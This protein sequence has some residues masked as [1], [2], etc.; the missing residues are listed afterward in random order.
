M[1]DVGIKFDQDKVPAI[2]SYIIG[3]GIGLT[4]HL[5]IEASHM[6]K[7]I[8]V[9]GNIPV[10]KERAGMH[11]HV[12]YKNLVAKGL[13]AEDVVRC[14]KFGAD[15]YGYHNYRNGMDWSRLVSAYLRHDMKLNEHN[16]PI[17]LESGLS[18]L[19]H[20]AANLQMLAE[21]IFLEI[22]NNDIIELFNNGNDE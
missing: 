11:I 6:A 19:A 10:N 18:H 12:L 21:F 15:K 14:C 4:G 7:L 16:E 13:Q 20:K 22:G 5:S 2:Y 17:D 3:R 8:E 1:T 9:L